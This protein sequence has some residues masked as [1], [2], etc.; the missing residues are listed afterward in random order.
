M[1]RQTRPLNERLIEEVFR[2]LL[3]KS[4]EAETS[5]PGAI[6]VYLATACFAANVSCW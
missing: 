4:P 1:T 3:A 5:P 6:D 2:E